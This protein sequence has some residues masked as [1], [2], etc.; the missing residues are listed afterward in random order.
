MPLSAAACALQC[1]HGGFAAAL[2]VASICRHSHE[3]R[4]CPVQ[5]VN[6]CKGK[7][8]LV[9]RLAMALLVFSLSYATAYM[10]TLTIAH[11][12]ACGWSPTAVCLLCG[13]LC[14]RNSHM[15]GRVCATAPACSGASE[16]EAWAVP[17]CWDPV[18]V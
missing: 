6:A 2:R 8:A 3:L 17:R 4:C 12:S 5:V 11:V 7:S 9:R 18:S 16:A 14:M 10:E 15:L 1:E 13:V